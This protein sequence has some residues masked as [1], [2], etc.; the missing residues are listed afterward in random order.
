MLGNRPLDLLDTD[1]GAGFVVEI[2]EQIA[3]SHQANQS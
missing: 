1:L 3:A 2:L